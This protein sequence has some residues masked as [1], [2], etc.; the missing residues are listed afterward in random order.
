MKAW[1]L[2]SV[3]GLSAK[4]SGEWEKAQSLASLPHGIFVPNVEDR[5]RRKIQVCMFLEYREKDLLLSVL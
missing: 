3:M 5:G 1:S 2:A 4:D